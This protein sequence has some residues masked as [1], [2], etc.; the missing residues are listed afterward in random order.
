MLA[1]FGGCGI[2]FLTE[3]VKNIFFGAKAR[4]LRYLTYRHIG[5]NQQKACFLQADIR[6][7]LLRCASGILIKLTYQKGF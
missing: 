7:V 3:C 1:E 6:E 4:F 5:V 2:Q